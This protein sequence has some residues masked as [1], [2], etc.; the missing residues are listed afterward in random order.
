MNKAIYE[1]PALETYLQDVS[2]VLCQST[3]DFTGG[4]EGYIEELL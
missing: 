2:L 4:N 3:G 1:S